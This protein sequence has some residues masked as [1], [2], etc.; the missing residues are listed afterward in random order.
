MGFSENVCH[1]KESFF[2]D[3]RLWICYQLNLVS[4]AAHQIPRH[5]ARAD[6]NSLC[7]TVGGETKKK[8]YFVSEKPIYLGKTETN[9]PEFLY[10]FRPPLIF[11]PSVEM[12]LLSQPTVSNRG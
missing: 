3:Y 12:N 2:A 5:H 4:P 8:L 11:Q 10:R 6:T 9:L 1:Y 7:L